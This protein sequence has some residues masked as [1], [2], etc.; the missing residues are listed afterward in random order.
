MRGI[1]YLQLT[2]RIPEGTK[3]IVFLKNV[4]LELILNL[5]RSWRFIAEIIFSLHQMF[6]S[7]MT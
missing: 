3:E 7:L 5:Q 2:A 1:V 4:Q 6:H